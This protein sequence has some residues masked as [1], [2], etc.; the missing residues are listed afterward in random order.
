MAGRRDEV[1]L[2][3][4]AQCFQDYLALEDKP[5]SRAQFEQNLK[6]K[7]QDPAFLGD[8]QPLLAPGTPWSLEEA[9]RW[10]EVELFPRLAGEPWR[11]M[12]DRH[13]QG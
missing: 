5:I 12:P 7:L 4:V 13:P 3:R 8:I 2:D 11:G 6:D 9:R 1:D 10:V